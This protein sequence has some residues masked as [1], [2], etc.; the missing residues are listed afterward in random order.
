MGDL[1]IIGDSRRI[2]S[3]EMDSADGIAASRSAVLFVRLI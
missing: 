3:A 2:A 1:R